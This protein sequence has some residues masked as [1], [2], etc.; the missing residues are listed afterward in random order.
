[1]SPGVTL[2]VQ[3]QPVMVVDIAN[4]YFIYYFHLLSYS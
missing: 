1:M 2:A 3:N 4:W